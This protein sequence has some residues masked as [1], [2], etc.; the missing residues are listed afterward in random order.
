MKHKALTVL[1]LL[2]SCASISGCETLRIAPTESAC[3]IVYVDVSA[4]ST[5]TLRAILANNKAL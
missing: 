5:E 2:L 1:G 4:D 3:D